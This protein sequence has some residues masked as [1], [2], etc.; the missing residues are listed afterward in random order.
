MN[1]IDADYVYLTNNSEVNILGILCFL[2][3]IGDATKINPL[4]F[5]FDI[6]YQ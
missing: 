2:P 3:L 5:D 6:I 4:I 1:V